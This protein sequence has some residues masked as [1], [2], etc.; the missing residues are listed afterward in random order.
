MKKRIQTGVAIAALWTGMA[1]A[2][3]A[4]QATAAK[5]VMKTL[6]GEVVGAYDNRLLLVRDEKVKTD[7]YVVTLQDQHQPLGIAR[8]H[9]IRVTGAFCPDSLLGNDVAA[10]EVVILKKATVP[11]RPLDLTPID[12]VR[13][14][15]AEGD[16]V[17]LKG[18]VKEFNYALMTLADGQD[19][20]RVDLGVTPRRDAFRTGQTLI[21]FGVVQRKAGLTWVRPVAIRDPAEFARSGEPDKAERIADLLAR[22]P[23]GQL[24]KAEG[25]ISIVI[26]GDASAPLLYDGK[27]MLVLFISDKYLSL[28][29]PGGEEAEVVGVFDEVEHKGRKYGALRDARI[30]SK[31]L[32]RKLAPMRGK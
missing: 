26:G 3:V 24:V 13:T 8:G 6:A 18:Q 1:G 25:R 28:D 30:D 2:A 16:L 12:N 4:Q 17:V 5:P 22:K 10:S 27:D 15:K 23:M 9:E 7:Y 31:A 11:P 14:A 21:V 19:E 32:L 20:I 29:I